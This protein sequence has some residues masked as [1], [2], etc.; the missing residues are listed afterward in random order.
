[1]SVLGEFAGDQNRKNGP[2]RRRQGFV[3]C[4]QLGRPSRGLGD[5]PMSVRAMKA[6]AVDFLTKPVLSGL[7]LQ[8]GFDDRDKALPIIFLTGIA[9]ELGVSE[10]TVKAHRGQVSR[11]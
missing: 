6:G 4:L 11:R 5:I 10:R 3:A 7:D 8:A 9:T 1:M 2:L